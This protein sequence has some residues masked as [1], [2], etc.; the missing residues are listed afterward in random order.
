MRSIR[1][2]VEDGGFSLL[3]TLLLAAKCLLE[4]HKPSAAAVHMLP[5]SCRFAEF[6]LL[7]Q[8]SSES[9]GQDSP[10]TTQVQIVVQVSLCML[11]CVTPSVQL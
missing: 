11:N 2:I 6:A 4:C 3:S 7:E 1:H 10:S 9:L 5:G 8:P